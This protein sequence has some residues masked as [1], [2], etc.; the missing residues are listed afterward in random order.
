MK[1]SPTYQMTFS[2]MNGDPNSLQVDWDIE[3]AIDSK[4]SITAE[5]NCQR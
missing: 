3:A 2:L 1:F 5:F 4:S